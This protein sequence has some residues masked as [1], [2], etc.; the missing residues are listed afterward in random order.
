MDEVFILPSHRGHGLGSA[1]LAS[2]L[3]VASELGLRAVQLES[4]HANSRASALYLRLGFVDGK[5][6]LLTKMLE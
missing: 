4:E 1:A 2:V 5:R 6:H 3:E